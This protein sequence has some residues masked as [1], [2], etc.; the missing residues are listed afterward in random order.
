MQDVVT[1]E[2]CP[3]CGGK[4]KYELEV[5]RASVTSDARKAQERTVFRNRIFRCPAVDE[6]F[7][8]RFS[9]HEDC[10]TEII[11]VH[12]G[13]LLP[14]MQSEDTTL[15]ESH[16]FVSYSRADEWLVTPIVHVIRA[17]GVSVFQD[18]DSIPYGKRWR[19]VIESSVQSASTVLVFWCN[20][21][22][23]SKEVQKELE[24]AIISGKDVVPTLLDDTPMAPQLSEFQFVDLRSIFPR[25]FA[26][27]N[28]PTTRGRLRD[29]AAEMLRHRLFSFS[30]DEYNKQ[31]DDFTLAA[32]LLWSHLQERAHT[33]H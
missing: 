14:D 16:V 5:V 19:P 11:E 4:H 9:L 1:I 15:L 20:H 7:E 24:L 13:R 27:P 12:V 32:A 26:G 23:A 33:I 30:K 17:V 28:D 31:P 2:S 10:N 21:S 25:H 29:D 22:Q 3:K 8:Y 6:S 18:I